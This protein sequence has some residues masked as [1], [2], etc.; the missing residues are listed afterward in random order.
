MMP[1][2]IR[3]TAQSNQTIAIAIATKDPP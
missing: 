3:Q 1:V 2:P